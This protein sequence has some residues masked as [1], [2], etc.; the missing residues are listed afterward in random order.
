MEQDTVYELSQLEKDKIKKIL[1]QGYDI[2]N[3]TFTD[4]KNLIS[5]IE[6]LGNL[7]GDLGHELS[8]L[9]IERKE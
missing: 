2:V 4:R 8:K 7:S 6:G 5:F 1:H 9:D 3:H